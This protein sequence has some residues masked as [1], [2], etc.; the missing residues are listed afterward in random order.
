MKNL[1]FTIVHTDTERKHCLLV[2]ATDH[3]TA[4]NKAIEHMKQKDSRVTYA[5]TELHDYWE[6]GSEIYFKILA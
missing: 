1:F 5:E 2:Q 3:K 6:H 4:Q